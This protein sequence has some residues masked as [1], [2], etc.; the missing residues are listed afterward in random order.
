MTASWRVFL[1]L[2]SPATSSHFT[3]GF[4]VI[5]AFP[6]ASFSAAFSSFFPSVFP[7]FSSSF[8]SAFDPPALRIRLAFYLYL[9]L[10]LRLGLGL[11]PG[12]GFKLGK[13]DGR[14]AM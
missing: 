7:A 13:F 8:F 9:G 1:A 2:S 5:I 3:F 14:G 4:S 11:G 10:G 12:L 6:N